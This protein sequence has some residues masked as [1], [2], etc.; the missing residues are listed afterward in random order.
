MGGD[1]CLCIVDGYVIVDDELMGLLGCLCEF[2][3]VGDCLELM[4]E[5]V[6]YVEM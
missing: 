2:F 6:G 5:D 3:V 4:F 1:G